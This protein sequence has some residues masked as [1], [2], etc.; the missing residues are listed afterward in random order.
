MRFTLILNAVAALLATTAV[1][2]PIEVQPYERAALPQFEVQKYER[3]ALQK[4]QIVVPLLGWIA[5][6]LDKAISNFIPL[7]CVD[8]FL[9]EKDIYY[10]NG[11]D[12]NGNN[13]LVC[14]Q[15]W[16]ETVLFGAPE[17]NV[18][19]CLANLHSEQADTCIDVKGS[20]CD[21]AYVSQDAAG[22]VE[23]GGRL[24]SLRATILGGSGTQADAQITPAVANTIE[25]AIGVLIGQQVTGAQECGPYFWPTTDNTGLKASSFGFGVSWIGEDD[26]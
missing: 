7:V 15:N 24:Q 11:W 5:S 23:S 17:V 10:V 3:A 18:A 12:Q 2:T 4:R 14:W 22:Y 6:L 26:C 19:K 25:A 16:T 21:S 13:F 20:T 9:N 8:G 1:A